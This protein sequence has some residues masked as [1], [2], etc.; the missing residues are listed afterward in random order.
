MSI[1]SVN[2]NKAQQLITRNFENIQTIEKTSFWLND[3]DQKIE[4]S[5]VSV[6]NWLKIRQK[7]GHECRLFPIDG[8]HGVFR[9]EGLEV[10]NNSLFSYKWKTENGTIEK[11]A[12]DCD[13]LIIDDKWRF[14]EFK[15]E[16]SSQDID[17]MNNNRNKGEAQL[18]RSMTSFKEQLNE[19]TL[20]CECVLVVPKF[21][22]FPKHKASL[23]PRKLR[24]LK[25]FGTELKEITNDGNESYDLF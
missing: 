17:Q 9:K 16:A 11:N 1:Y 12:G 5:S 14:I 13:C 6:P 22:S 10:R 18:A 21:F 20:K 24:F 4:S 2:L 19:D 15:I 7:S 3:V 25:L 8:N 23:L